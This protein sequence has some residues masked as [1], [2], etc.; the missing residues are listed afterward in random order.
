MG[1]IIV[2]NLCWL[3]CYTNIRNLK[4]QS[5]VI[6]CCSFNLSDYVS[7]C[8]IRIF[9][10]RNTLFDLYTSSRFSLNP[11][12]DLPG[13]E[14]FFRK[15]LENNVGTQIWK[16]IYSIIWP[17]S[18][19]TTLNHHSAD[20]TAVIIDW[21]IP[22]WKTLESLNNRGWLRI[23]GFDV[24]IT[25]SIYCIFRNC[26]PEDHNNFLYHVKNIAISLAYVFTIR[27]V[28]C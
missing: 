17:T 15:I 20:R 24:W 3:K 27:L 7:P 11:E 23:P 14:K 12:N 18:L 6:S 5:N 19:S 2:S 26:V 4:V 25:T 22:A 9:D 1:E 28:F 21:P 10:M 8:C 16:C 13:V